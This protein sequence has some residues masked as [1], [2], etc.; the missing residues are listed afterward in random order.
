MYILNVADFYVQSAHSS[1]RSPARL[2]SF[3]AHAVLL[4]WTKLNQGLLLEGDDTDTL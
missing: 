1:A 3:I 2:P 4:K